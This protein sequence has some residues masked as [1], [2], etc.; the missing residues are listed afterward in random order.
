M[1]TLLSRAALAA[2]AMALGLS[3]A[4]ASGLQATGTLTVK[5]QINGS[6]TVASPTVNFPAQT[7]SDQTAIV[8]TSTSIGVTCTPST[9]PWNLVFSGGS[10]YSNGFRNMVSGAGQIP[11]GLYKDSGY[12][13]LI[14]AAGFTSGST[15]SVTIYLQATIPAGATTGTY[16]DTVALTLN[17]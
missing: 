7:S 15:S 8:G 13:Q 2:A 1:I 10:S 12:T 9:T 5:L 17:Y 11:Y 14:D 16:Q 4:N 6:C 3:G